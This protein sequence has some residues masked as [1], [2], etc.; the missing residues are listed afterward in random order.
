[1]SKEQKILDTALRLFVED[2]F[3]G[4]PTSKI[5]KEAGVANGTLFHYFATKETLIKELYIHVKN[6]L[7]HY[8]FS[9]IDPNDDIKTNTK[10]VFTNAIHWCLANPAKFHFTHQVYFSPHVTKIPAEVVQ[11][12]TKMHTNLIETAKAQ[13]LLKPMPTDLIFSL[14]NSHMIGIYQYILAQPETQQSEIIE[15]GFDMLWELISNPQ[16]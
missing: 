16:P 10:K 8:L 1:M 6:E 4:T 15:Q 3:Q 7:N 11:E 9:K 2:G 13:G 12:Q 14:V 5:A